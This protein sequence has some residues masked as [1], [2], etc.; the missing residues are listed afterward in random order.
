MTQKLLYIHIGL[1]KTG[2][3][4]I[5]QALWQNKDA[6]SDYGIVV[7]GSGHNNTGRFHQIAW[8]LFDKYRDADRDKAQKIENGTYLDLIE[9]IGQSEA[10]QFVIS[11]EALSRL[12]VQEIKKLQTAL[13]DSIDAHIIVYV[14]NPVEWK[15]S[16][17]AQR[18]KKAGMTDTFEAYV[19]SAPV[20]GYMKVVHR[21]S[22]CFGKEKMRVRIY[23]EVVREPGLMVDFWTTLGIP[24]EH[25][26]NLTEPE[27]LNVTPSH[28][29]LEL[30][31]QIN[32]KLDG[33]E[34]PIPQFYRWIR[35]FQPILDKQHGGERFRPSQEAMALIENLATESSQQVA[36]DFFDRDALFSP[37]KSYSGTDDT[38]EPTKDDLYELIAFLGVQITEYMQSPNDGNPDKDDELTQLRQKVENQQQRIKKLKRQLKNQET[39]NE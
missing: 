18:I 12:T 19:S 38:P 11:S 21:W 33:T 37:G 17:W 39:D 32:Q 7:P 31:R 14:R 26:A 4:S 24:A 13:G 28:V 35:D 10:T 20:D 6:L 15:A 29:W 23:D 9:E 25:Q 16:Q 5:Q 1:E 8:S 36:Q 22:E 3:K 30:Q 27:R 2:T 34:R